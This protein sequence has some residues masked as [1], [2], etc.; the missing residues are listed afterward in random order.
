MDII[1]LT[2]G[3]AS[4][5]LGV[6]TATIRLMVQRGTLPVAAVTVRGTRL[7]RRADVEQLA[8]TRAERNASV[9]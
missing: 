6:T 4:R 2:A 8:R 7:F 5:V 9:A 1:F 3:D